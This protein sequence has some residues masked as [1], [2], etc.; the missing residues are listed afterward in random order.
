[1]IAAIPVVKKMTPVE[2]LRI[3]PLTKPSLS[4]DDN[5]ISI[6]RLHCE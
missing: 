1:M 6:E 5:V 4:F 3:D 2:G